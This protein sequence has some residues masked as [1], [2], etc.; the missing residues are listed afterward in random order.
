MEDIRYAGLNR[1]LVKD[2]EL[3]K[4]D[5]ILA[6]STSVLSYGEILACG[7]IKEEDSIPDFMFNEGD[8][9]YFLS[10]AG[11]VLDLPDGQFRLLN[12]TDILIG[13]KN[14]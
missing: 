13:E 14:G 3:P 12:I 6:S 7:A 9:V 2:L 10:R 8:K 4:V 11:L 5:S 1:V